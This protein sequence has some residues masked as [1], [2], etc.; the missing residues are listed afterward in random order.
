[1]CNPVSVNHLYV[2]G[3]TGDRKRKKKG[4]IRNMIYT[5]VLRPGWS[6][7]FNNAAIVANWFE[8][9]S[10]AACQSPWLH[11]PIVTLDE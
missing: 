2:S 4:K 9:D 5:S 8:R 10:S 7:V 6:L 3:T 1:M 11:S